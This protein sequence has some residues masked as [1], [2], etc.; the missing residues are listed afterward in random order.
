ME[1]GIV[2]MLQKHAGD[3]GDFPKVHAATL[4]H[5]AETEN[6]AALIASCL[7]TLEAHPSKLKTGFAKVTSFFGDMPTSLAYDTVIKNG[8]TE[9]AS[10][11]QEIASYTAL[12]DAAT[13]LGFPDIA[14]TCRKILAEEKAQAKHLGSQLKQVSKLYLASLQ[15][16]W[17]APPATGRKHEPK[18]A[19][20]K[21]VP[22]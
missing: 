6:H 11:H 10:E 8:I 4:K 19:K 1:M 16:D 20:R 17:D 7:E 9:F 3:A 21:A 22:R 14:A 15:R 5:L 13:A 12:I 2:T 18:P